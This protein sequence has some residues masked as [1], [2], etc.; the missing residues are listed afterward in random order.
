MAAILI[1]PR[2]GPVITVLILIGL[3]CGVLL[4][5]NAIIRRPEITPAI[6]G[7]KI[8]ESMGCF[9]CHGPEGFGGIPDP[10]SPAGK[11]PGWEIGTAILYI[12]NESDIQEWILNGTVEDPHKHIETEPETIVPMPAYGDILSDGELSD[13]IAYF[14]AVSGYASSIPDE[15]YEGSV[16]AH[17]LGCFGCHGPSGMGG[18]PNPRSFTGIIPAW[19]GDQFNE[20]VKNDD[21]LRE[22]ILDGKI[23]RL[24]D[25]PLGKFFLKRQVLQMPGYRDHLTADELNSLI[26]YIK[27]L[28]GSQAQDKEADNPIG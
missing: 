13:L 25:N 8:A 11:A 20:L 22:W 28:Q 24:M 23:K 10:I 21:E 5:A 27:W 14:K 1:N 12:N 26:I 3:G 16:I 15:A 18:I 19:D 9:G 7:K 6:R 17:N 4:T 2:V